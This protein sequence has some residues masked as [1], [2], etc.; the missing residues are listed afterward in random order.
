MAHIK[1]VN[2]MAH[3][4]RRRLTYETKYFLEGVTNKIHGIHIF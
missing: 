3:K 1:R 2:E 4:S